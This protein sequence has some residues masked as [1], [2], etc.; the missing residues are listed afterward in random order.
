VILLRWLAW[1][2]ALLLVATGLAP[3]WP[4]AYSV[5]VLGGTLAALIGLSI[6]L[7]RLSSPRPLLFVALLDLLVGLSAVAATGG[8]ASPFLLSSY[9]ALLLPF[10]LLQ[11]RGRLL[12]AALYMLADT[13][14]MLLSDLPPG[15]VQAAPTTLLLRL[16]LPFV[17]ALLV[18]PE[19]PLLLTPQPEVNRR[20]IRA[21]E[22]AMRRFQRIALLSGPTSD[23][24]ETATLLEVRVAADRG[25]RELHSLLSLLRPADEASVDL[26]AQLR[27]LAASFHERSHVICALAVE[28]QPRPLPPAVDATL[29]GVTAEALANVEKHAKAMEAEIRLRYE[30]SDVTLTVRDDGVGLMDGPIDRPGCRGL[31][32]LQY[33]VAELNGQLEVFEGEPGGVVVRVTVPVEVYAT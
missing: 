19:V 26:I 11:R 6:V 25:E 28:G 30:A 32:A 2:T 16:G 12:I 27:D 9:S 10:R 29:I 5:I 7:P 22:G 4:L 1:L 23:G 3:N 33:R 31:R 21:V 20:L 24:R 13:G 15:A 8:W 17:L 18:Q 14:A